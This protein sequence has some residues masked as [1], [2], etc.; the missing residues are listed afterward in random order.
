MVKKLLLVTVLAIFSSNFIHAQDVNSISNLSKVNVD[1][2]SEDQIAAYLKRAQESGLSEQQLLLLA[3]QRGMSDLQIQKLRNRI[4]SLGDSSGQN[5]GTA[6]GISRIREDNQAILE[7][8]LSLG[9]FDDLVELDSIALLEELLLEKELKIF[10]SEIFKDR[11][12]NF[13]PSINTPTPKNYQIGP[14][15]EVI[16]DIWGASEQSYM[17]TV[18]PEGSI[19]VSNLGPIYINGLTVERASAKVKSRLSK[20]Y[21]GL[22]SRN[23]QSPN[24]FFQMSLGATRSIKVNVIGEITNPGTYTLSSFSTAFNALYYAGGPTENGSM[25]DIQLVRNNKVV[26]TLDIYK[27]LLQGQLSND[28]KLEDQDV[29][30]V[31]TYINRVT[32]DGEVK[33]PGIYEPMDNESLY[34]VL[35]FAGGFTENA[36]TS[37]IQIKRN[38]EKQKELLT[39]DKEAYKNTTISNGDIINVNQLIDRYT[40][41]VR[42]E[43]AVNMP[44]EY[45]LTE[46]LTAKQLIANAEGLR[47]DAFTGRGLIIRLNDD[48]TISNLSFEVSDLLS[49]KAED[50]ILK[51]EDLIKISSIFDL[52]EDKTLTIK[53][54]V[55]NP[56]IFPFV[57]KMTVEDLIILSDG[58]RESAS[59]KIIEVAR[60]PEKT[61]G[62]SSVVSETFEFTISANAALS[63]DASHF[64][65]EPF[66][67]V[68]IR[69]SPGYSEQVS[70]EIE[71]EVKYPGI[72]TLKVRNERISE[73][74][75]RAGGITAYG[76]PRGA[77]LIR[78]TEFYE[79][80][81]ADNDAAVAQKKEA[82]EALQ[83]QDSLVDAVEIKQFE[84]VGIDLEK[85]LQ[86]P[87][88]KFD[89]ILQEGDVLSIPRQLETVRVKGEVLYPLTIKHGDQLSFKDYIAAS[90]G[91]N[92]RARLAKSFVIYPNGTAAKTKRFLWFKNY[93]VVEPGSEIIVP[94][95][96]TRSRMSIQEILA[97]TTT[98]STLT[99]LIDRLGN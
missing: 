94:R 17:L 44:G 79:A 64:E 46:G 56:G 60:R 26:G 95:R 39:V 76:Y 5:T 21:S 70:V 97:I 33:R 12:L 61:D 50:I 15:D 10:G 89:L 86:N 65:L 8:E 23:D 78:R 99:L 9:I 55:M 1:D 54:E 75:S 62:V 49:G 53:G 87:R 16:I 22:M 20:I 2:L 41:R 73:L 13:E 52:G 29:V 90:G 40:N 37:S 88:S 6:D 91:T 4:N 45:E 3:K 31:K 35:E 42:I 82:L 19:L 24:T 27:Y 96:P 81:K 7:T 58:M 83:E 36:Y 18:S 30:L 68:T 74:I 48:Y 80:D 32:V 57:S 71:G 28:L 66:D 69:K 67:I 14:G 93:P 77:Q 38:G 43:G 51:N 84:T 98:L 47:G 72:Y 11:K 85:I 34:S 63:Q 92:E 59:A 25:R